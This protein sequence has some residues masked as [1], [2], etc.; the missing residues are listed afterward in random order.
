MKR[1]SL[2]LALLLLPGAAL[3]QQSVGAANFATGQ[4]SVGT[5]ATL[6][7][8]A[9]SGGI[10]VS[11]VSITIVNVGQTVSLCVGAAGVSAATGVCLPAVAGASTQ[12]RLSTAFGATA[13]RIA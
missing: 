9:R 11:R 1:L 6:I 2:V 7:A 12:W 8:A 4:V 5:G 3:A 10:G 13:A